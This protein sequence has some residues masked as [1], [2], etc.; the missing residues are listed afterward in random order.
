MKEYD[1][2]SGLQ[3]HA[4]TYQQQQADSKKEEREAWIKDRKPSSLPPNPGQNP[5]PTPDPPKTQQ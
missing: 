3:G 1:E 2:N 5:K 4:H